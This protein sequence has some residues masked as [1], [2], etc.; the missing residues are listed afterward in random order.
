VVLI[1]VDVDARGVAYHRPH[2]RT[3]RNRRERCEWD[4]SDRPVPRGAR[5]MRQEH[6]NRR[7]PAPRA[8]TDASGGALGP[9]SRRSPTGLRR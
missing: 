1:A 9:T 6:A 4:G 8:A 7:Q 2:C 3:A 5:G